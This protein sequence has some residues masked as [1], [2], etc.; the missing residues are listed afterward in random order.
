MG[1]LICRK[2]GYKP[3][4][5][6]EIDYHHVVPKEFLG[7]DKDGR[8]GFCQENKGNDCHRKLH[9]FF[10]QDTE[11]KELCKKKFKEWLDGNS[12]AAPK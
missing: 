1:N 8:V 4:N 6:S 9:S 12:K 7:T 11:I 3:D 2:C 5:E 10:R